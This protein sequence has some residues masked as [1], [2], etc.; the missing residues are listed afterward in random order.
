M[1]NLPYQSHQLIEKYHLQ[2]GIWDHY[3]YLIKYSPL[4]ITYTLKYLALKELKWL[5]LAMINVNNI[6]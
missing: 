3:E 6:S 2:S 4:G 1:Y 5:Q